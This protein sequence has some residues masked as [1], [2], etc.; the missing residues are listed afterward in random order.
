MVVV[1]EVTVLPVVALEDFVRTTV[2]VVSSQRGQG[3]LDAFPGTVLVAGVLRGR[4][5]RV[6][7]HVFP[8]T[9]L[10]VPGTQAGQGA[11][12]QPLDGF[13]AWVRVGDVSLQGAIRDLIVLGAFPQ[14]RR[15]TLVEDVVDNVTLN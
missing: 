10:V 14:S 15:E 6:T 8:Q 5:E 1:D 4:L 11:V 9:I 3:I 12:D 13:V 7:D 2:E